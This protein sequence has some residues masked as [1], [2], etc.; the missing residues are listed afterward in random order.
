MR[1][2]WSL[3]PYFLRYPW[4]LVGGVFFVIASAAFAVYPA[5]FI[6]EAF[7]TVAEALRAQSD[8]TLL[9]QSLL[10][11]SALILLLSALRGGF[12]FLMRQ[13]LIVM[14]RHIEFDLKNDI[15]KHYQALDQTFYRRN[16]TGDL[17]NRVSEDVSRVRMYLG[18]GVMYTINT[19]FSTGLTLIFMIQV[20]PKLSLIT[21]AP[22]PV[23]VWA[24]YR[25][26]TMINQRSH[27]V[28]QQQSAISTMAQETFS[29]IRVLKVY[30]LE[31]DQTQRYA[32]SSEKSY[33]LNRDLYRVNAL[34]AP[35]MMLL[36]GLSTVLAVWI[37]GEGV[38]EGRLSPGV[39][40]EF[41]YYVGLLTW[42]IASIGWVMSLIQRAE[43]SME[44]IND[45]LRV[46]PAVSTPD[47]AHR[48]KVQGAWTFENASYTYPDS[49][50]QALK[51]VSFAVNPGE[52][53][54]VVGRTG[55]GKS[56]LVGL[57]NRLMDPIEGRI[58][59]DG[60][61][62][63]RW[64]LE[65]LRASIGTV[66]QDPFL[67]SDSIADNISFGSI[68]A[69]RSDVER[70]AELADVAEDIRGFA[71]GYETVVGERG[72]TLSGGQKQ[73][74]SIARALMKEP[75]MLLFDD[76]LSAVDTETEVTILSNLKSR[77]N[78][79][80]AVLITQRLSCVHLADRILVLDQGELVQQ[81]SHLELLAQP[82][83]YA[84]LYAL[85]S[86]KS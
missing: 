8:S 23:L 38:I 86:Q 6:R 44:R 47:D 82:G 40:A 9:F 25:V 30:S 19:A 35:L 15:Y 42:P 45:F 76:A 12:T 64:D 63:R 75:P 48:A 22:M 52:T 31:K 10:G 84:E 2:L 13:T 51:N 60:V 70:Q 5:I 71:K 21:L 53:I 69:D 49:G 73:R 57:M 78:G 54:V 43:A 39:I 37:G 58:L 83:L 50:I 32:E 46:V 7:D 14:S 56:T 61:D 41:I 65:A 3:N 67:F 66:P 72:V 11:Y 16:S 1:A 17:M 59:L 27:A 81:G 34:F 28:Q 24:I 26:S 36:V 20:D 4:H 68:N 33:Q 55:S 77:L 29:G 80:T 18:P 74:V 62:L 85:Q 79:L